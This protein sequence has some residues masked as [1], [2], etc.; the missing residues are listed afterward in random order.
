MRL[1][2][3]CHALRMPRNFSFDFSG[4]S[5]SALSPRSSLIDLSYICHLNFLM[6]DRTSFTSSPE[7]FMFVLEKWYFVSKIVLTYCENNF[8]NKISVHI[9]LRLIN[10]KSQLP[11]SYQYQKINL[12]FKILHS[13]WMANQ[14]WIDF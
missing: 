4:T 14:K 10:F 9:I 13:D 7:F 12:N 6:V 2:V 1:F 8:G 11:T 3:I 5:L